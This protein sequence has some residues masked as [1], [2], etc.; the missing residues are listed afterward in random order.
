MSDYEQ[1]IPCF[2]IS[3]WEYSLWVN[4]KGIFWYQDDEK[5]DDSGMMGFIRKIIKMS[6][7]KVKLEV[8]I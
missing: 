4:G 3:E 5:G 2:P 1:S 7:I 6:P 8:D